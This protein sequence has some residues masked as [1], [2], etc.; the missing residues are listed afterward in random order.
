VTKINRHLSSR[1]NKIKE[2][3]PVTTPLIK[4]K[5]NLWL[6]NSKLAFGGRANKVESKQSTMTQVMHIGKQ[7]TQQVV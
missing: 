2:K 1:Q 6:N 4:K 3:R 5:N 7:Y